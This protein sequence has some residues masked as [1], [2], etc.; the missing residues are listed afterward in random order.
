M[1]ENG[2]DDRSGGLVVWLVP[3]VLVGYCGWVIWHAAQSGIFA[4]GALG[5]YSMYPYVL[6][7]GLLGSGSVLLQKQGAM[8]WPFLM[9]FFSYGVALNRMEPMP[10]VPDDMRWVFDFIGYIT[11]FAVVAAGVAHEQRRR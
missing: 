7:L 3:I 1:N 4:W 11:A 2:G 10:V 9:L 8:R 6:V 5:Y